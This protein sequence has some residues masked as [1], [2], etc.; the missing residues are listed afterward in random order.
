MDYRMFLSLT[1]S[2]G[3]KGALIRHQGH[4]HEL[5]FGKSRREYL[6][7]EVRLFCNIFIKWLASKLGFEGGRSATWCEK[8]FWSTKQRGQTEAWRPKVGENWGWAWIHSKSPERVT[9]RW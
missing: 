4:Q 3:T 9:F 7:C 5:T 1:H 2:L 6:S 8:G